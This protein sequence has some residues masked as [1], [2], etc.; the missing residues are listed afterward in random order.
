[1]AGANQLARGGR[2]FHGYDALGR[3]TA[4]SDSLGSRTYSHNNQG[5][6]IIAGMG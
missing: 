6:L 5:L 1:M 4:R 2:I 3:R